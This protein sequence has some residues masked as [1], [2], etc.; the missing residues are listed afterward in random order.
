MRAIRDHQA[1]L[2]GS[3]FFLTGGLFTMAAHGYSLGSAARMGPGD[4]P[5][6]LGIILALLGALPIFGAFTRRS[7][8]TR[9]ESWDWRTLSLLVVSIIS[10]AIAMNWLGFVPA[11]RVLVLL[12]S[13]ASHEFSWKGAFANFLVILGLNLSVFV[14]GLSLPLQLWPAIG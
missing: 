1:F 7:H 4:F 3:L 12:S 9:L 6:C 13:A 8:R 14:Y 10:F 11:L 2:S 5:F